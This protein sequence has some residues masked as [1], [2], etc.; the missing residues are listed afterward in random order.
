LEDIN[1]LLNSGEVANLFTIDEK[2]EICEKMR[3]LDKQ[4]EKS[5]QV[6]FFI[7][8]ACTNA[9]EQTVDVYAGFILQCMSGLFNDSLIIL[10]C[11]L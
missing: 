11:I 2:A 1:N 4:R 8:S 3:Q 10:I 7:N 5:L 9:S 6:R